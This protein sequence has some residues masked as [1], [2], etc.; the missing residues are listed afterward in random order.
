MK[1]PT[2]NNVRTIIATMKSKNIQRAKLG[3]GVVL[4][5]GGLYLVALNRIVEG[6]IL[7]GIG[8]FIMGL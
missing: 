1:S 3:L 5:M 8:I 2:L 6:I 4:I 7:M